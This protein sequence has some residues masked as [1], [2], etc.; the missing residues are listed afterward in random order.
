MAEILHQLISS[1]FHYLQGFIYPRWCRISS[2]NNITLVVSE[3]LDFGCFDFSHQKS[4]ESSTRLLQAVFLGFFGGDLKKKLRSSK[5]F[6]EKKGRET[7]V[8]SLTRGIFFKMPCCFMSF[9]DVIFT[10]PTNFQWNSTPKKYQKKLT[11]TKS[12][13]FFWQ[14]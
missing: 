6:L 7:H 3:E 5:I 1:L 4:P 11:S 14:V 8:L 12:H 9:P 13:H 2:I 10:P